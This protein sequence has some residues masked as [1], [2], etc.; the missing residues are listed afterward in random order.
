M[1][2]IVEID[3]WYMSS[4]LVELDT[5]YFT[6]WNGTAANIYSNR[7]KAVVGTVTVLTGSGD[8]GTTAKLELRAPA[9]YPGTY[10][11]T[12]DY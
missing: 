2:L 5:G 1:T 10:T 3:K 6:S 12:K 7:A 9:E 11:F 8:P 4:S